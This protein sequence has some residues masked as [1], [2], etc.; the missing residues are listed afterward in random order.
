MN[1]EV[2]FSRFVG[3]AIVIICILMVVLALLSAIMQN[4]T[5]DNMIYVDDGSVTMLSIAKSNII[6]KYVDVEKQI[7]SDNRM[8]DLKVRLPKINIQ[9]ETV[10][11]INDKIYNIY[12]NIYLEISNDEAI[13]EV[14]ID[15]T[16]EYLDNDTVLAIT[17]TEK[18]ARN[19]KV[20]EIDT[21]FAYD[22]KNDVEK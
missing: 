13:E 12:Q 15:Y 8:V 20:E 19:N 7:E 14:S 9:T 1:K 11:T 17:V 3:I 16:Y 21:K 10:N 18:V 22:M 4:E 6:S 2:K 5:S